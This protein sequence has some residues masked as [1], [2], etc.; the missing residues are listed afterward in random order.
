[1]IFMWIA[2][3]VSYYLVNFQLKYLPGSIY[4][5]SLASASAEIV[6][7]LSGCII[8]AKK[9][10]RTSFSILYVLCIVGGVLIILFGEKYSAWLP[11]FL[12]LIRMGCAGAFN[13]AYIA[14]IDVF[15]TL[16]KSTAT[17]ICNFFARIFCVLAP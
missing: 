8:Y 14:P 7:S 3:A 9:G 13:L 10:I 16:F 4:T 1:M 6:G 5:N 11:L 15:P 12:V 2:C 17:G